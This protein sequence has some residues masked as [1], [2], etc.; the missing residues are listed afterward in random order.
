MTVEFKDK[1]TLGGGRSIEVLHSGM[2]L[3][4]HIRQHPQTGEYHYYAGPSNVLTPS[5]S[6][7]NIETLKQK[8]GATLPIHVPR[9]GRR[10]G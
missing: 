2:G 10:L 3:V 1:S 9:L 5:L 7:G 4:G 6:H 8:V